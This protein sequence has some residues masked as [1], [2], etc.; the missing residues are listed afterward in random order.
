MELQFDQVKKRYGKQLA[1]DHFN[2]TLS[3]GVY[4]LLGHKAT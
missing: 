3:E 4:G 1:L 2:V